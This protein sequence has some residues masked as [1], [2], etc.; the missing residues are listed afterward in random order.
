MSKRFLQASAS[1]ST[2]FLGSLAVAA[3]SL[4][5][6]V[7][8]AT[9][10]IAEG[11]SWRPAAL[12]GADIRSLAVDPR[13][14]EV[15][16]AGTSAG[17]LYRSTDGG[18]TWQEAGP[19][20]PLR[21]YVIGSLF[22]DPNRSGRLWAGLWGIWG[23]GA[24]AFSDDQ[25]AT[26]ALRGTGLANEQI[27]AITAVPGVPGKFFAA[28][29][30]GV[31]STTDD[32]MT[33]QHATA[34]YADIVNVSSLEVDPHEP[35]RVLAGTWRRA[36][37]SDDG[38]RT[39]RGVFTGMV[40]DSEVFNMSP[41][42]RHPGV[43]WASTCGWVYQSSDWGETW[44]RFQNGLAERRTP[45]IEVLFDG[46]LLAGTVAG[47][48]LSDDRGASWHRR[49]PTDL[50]ILAIASHPARPNRVW[51]G[52]EG[53]GVY[54]SDDRGSSFRPSA[55]GMTNVRVAA[56][57]S[58]GGE[59]FAAVPHAGPGSGIY[60]SRDGGRSFVDAHEPLPTVL[61]LVADGPEIWA[62]T[63]QGLFMAS[64]GRSWSRVAELGSQRVE[65]VVAHGGRVV[66]RTA[67]GLFERPPGK[68]LFAAVTYK[69][70]PP[71]ALAASAEALWVADAEGLY[72][73]GADGNHPVA[74][75]FPGGRVQVLGESLLYAGREGVW[76]RPDQASPWSTLHPLSARTLLTGDERYPLVM[77][78]V[79]VQ[80]ERVWLYEAATRRI[81]DLG[82]ATTGRDVLS[83][84]VVDR[85]V[86][87]GTS[88]YGLEL[89]DLPA[90]A[91]H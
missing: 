27:Y 9:P 59:V 82:A 81:H 26:F 84:L 66:A 86:L 50:A 6:T 17:H 62:A 37:R 68:P 20:L 36:Y 29:R 1:F 33:W 46:R 51:I 67:K 24:V 30:S 18:S 41:D 16:Y 89:L 72:R 43:V 70:G 48:Y 87:L 10:S 32:G 44:R 57:A 23:G 21:G 40:L 52:T 73:L 2:L 78:E 91:V 88:G 35:N 69:H 25:G 90:P 38:G 8:V 39:W 47:L 55:T 42:I 22:F 13:D 14:P 85:R 71:R 7:A 65:Q 77:V 83:A 80:P 45:S 5:L 61:D 19:G 56:L 53:A 79:G 58:F 60:R 75:P 64:G 74:T 11:S 12:F 54:R 28:A 4:P 31:W 63:E 15:V 3:T 49:T 34:P 76:L